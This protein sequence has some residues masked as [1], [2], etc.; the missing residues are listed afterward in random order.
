MPSFSLLG[1]K[2]LEPL[3]DYVIYLSVRGE[4][5]RRLI[6]AGIDELGYAETPPPEAE[7]QLQHG[8]AETEGSLLVEEILLRVAESWRD[9]Q[10]SV[11][12]VPNWSTLQG[13]A[14]EQSIGR[15]KE[16]FHG[17]I[18]NCVGCHGPQG[19]GQMATL[20]YDDWSKEYSTRIG[21]TPSDREAMRPFRDAGALNPRPIKPRNLQP[22][23]FQ[24]GGEGETLYRRITQGIAGTPMPAIEVVEEENGK[25]LTESQVWDLVRYIQSL[26]ASE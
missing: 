11:T 16:I 25:G 10:N 7:F 6:A 21:L 2:D 14:L 5:E 12:S 4:V 22:G 17:Q 18:V 26:S 1:S 13:Q 9:A 8:G 23:V 3:V 19:N 24:G 15:G 20:D